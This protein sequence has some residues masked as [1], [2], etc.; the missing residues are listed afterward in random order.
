MPT[1]KSE[2]VAGSHETVKNLVMLELTL[3]LKPS[4]EEAEFDHRESFKSAQT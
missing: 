3:P 1:P 2:T 4:S